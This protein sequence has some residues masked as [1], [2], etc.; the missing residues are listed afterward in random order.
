MAGPAIAFNQP[1]IDEQLPGHIA[2]VDSALAK[3]QRDHPGSDRAKRLTAHLAADRAF[4]AEKRGFH[5]ALATKTFTDSLTIRLGERVIKVMHQDRAITPGD[6]YLVLPKEHV[7]VTGDLLINPITFA[8]FCYPAGWIAT[9]HAI[10]ALDASLIVPGHGG[11][12]RD[13]TLLHETIALLER[14]QELAQKAKAAGRTVDEAKA[15]VLADSSVLEWREAITGGDKEKESDFAV[16]L[17]E[18]FVKRVYAE[19]DGPLDDRI[20]REF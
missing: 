18:W 15:D 10:D 8:L 19:A 1:G 6:A 5:P 14:E 9:L 11:A 2:Q 3:E 12:M 17:V 20:P 7:V 13:E 16:Y 4:L